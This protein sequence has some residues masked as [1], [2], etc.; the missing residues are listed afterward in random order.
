MSVRWKK[1]TDYV[2]F[3]KQRLFNGK[4]A[5][6]MFNFVG[7]SYL[8]TPGFTVA[9]KPAIKP[10]PM[11]LRR[12]RSDLCASSVGRIHHADYSPSPGSFRGLGG[13]QSCFQSEINSRNC[14][15]GMKRKR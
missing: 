14:A 3:G 4:E 15:E 8:R 1:L 10:K 12:E 9:I 2:I 5:G 7:S 13:L 6:F 11:T